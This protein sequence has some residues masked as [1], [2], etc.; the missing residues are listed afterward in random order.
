MYLQHDSAYPIHHQ[1]FQFDICGSAKCPNRLMGVPRLLF[2]GYRSSFLEV[3]RLSAL[4]T[5]RLYPQEIY[6]TLISVGG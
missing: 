5:G 2:N 1:G 6:L 4:G 3:I